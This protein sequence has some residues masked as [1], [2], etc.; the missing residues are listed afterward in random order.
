MRR[1]AYWAISPGGLLI[2]AVTTEP[3]AAFLEAVRR[4]M[5]AI[6]QALGSTVVDQR[7]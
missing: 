5:K 4:S 1:G 7:C 2:E 3:S 6:R